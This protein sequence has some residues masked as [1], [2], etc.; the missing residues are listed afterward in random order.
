MESGAASRGLPWRWSG[1]AT[2]WCLWGLIPFT[3]CT[4]CPPDFSTA[5]N[6]ERLNA[7]E[8]NDRG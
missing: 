8:G 2:A 7:G 3:V 4:S 1:K 5:G 6:R